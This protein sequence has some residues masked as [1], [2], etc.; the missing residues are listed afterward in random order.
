[1]VHRF[2]QHIVR[3]TVLTLLTITPIMMS[4]TYRVCSV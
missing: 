2:Q 4:A 3:C 1:V